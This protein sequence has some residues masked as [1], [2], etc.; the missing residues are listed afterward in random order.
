MNSDKAKLEP[1]SHDYSP[2][3]FFLICKCVSVDMSM[4]VGE[5]LKDPI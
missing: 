5:N 1:E 3:L 2:I 4:K